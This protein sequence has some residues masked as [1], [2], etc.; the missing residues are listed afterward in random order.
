MHP[1]RV[2]ATLALVSFWVAI[3][4]EVFAADQ[5]TSISSTPS[6]DC[7]LLAAVV[8]SNDKGLRAAAITNLLSPRS[9]GVDR[10]WASQGI[11]VAAPDEHDHWMFGF[12][13]PNYSTD[14]LTAKV[15]YD[16]VFPFRGSHNFHCSLK[17][18]D[19]RWTLTGCA[20][21]NIAD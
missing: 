6:N 21:G 8:N 12:G 13:K 3:P 14:G 4:A 11:S 1:V 7:Q 10:D 19:G 17:K 18:A 9:Y 20:M 16:A 2:I 5:T 15:E